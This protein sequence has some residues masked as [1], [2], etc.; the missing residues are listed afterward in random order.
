MEKMDSQLLEKL[1]KIRLM[2]F[3]VDG[4][5]TD[6]SLF[7]TAEDDFKCFHAQDGL[8]LRLLVESQIVVAV[9]SGRKSAAVSKRMREL[10]IHELLLGVENKRI[11]MEN[12]KKK[13]ALAWENCAFMGDDLI[14]IPALR[15][16]GVKLAPKN[17]CAEVQAMVDW[18]SPQEGGKG[19]VRS[20]VEWLLKAQGT[21]Q[22]C[23]N[24][25]EKQ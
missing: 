25:F 4:V 6:G 16:C 7:Y 1:K 18:L 10:N 17:A 14:D 5:M 23:V 2:A 19:A 11:A 15:L 21:W 8:A 24:F 9:I 12:L 3:D 20:A 13:Y 22:N